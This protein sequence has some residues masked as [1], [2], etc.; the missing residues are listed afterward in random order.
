MQSRLMAQ[1]CHY[2]TNNSGLCFFAHLKYFI[3]D[4]TGN[5]SLPSWIGQGACRNVPYIQH[6]QSTQRISPRSL[7][8]SA[9]RLSARCLSIRRASAF[10]LNTLRRPAEIASDFSNSSRSL[11]LIASSNVIRFSGSPHR[12][13]S[14]M[15]R[16]DKPGPWILLAI[17]NRSSSGSGFI[18]QTSSLCMHSL[19]YPFVSSYIRKTSPD[20][21]STSSI[22]RRFPPP[23]E[24]HLR[25]LR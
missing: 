13:A 20:R 18:R 12:L 16:H 1:P 15:H 10:S 19:L 4:P 25:Q 6:G 24:Q 11:S 8:F 22:S 23:G 5:R 7:A 17:A 3:Y 2:V 14:P 9:S 21:C